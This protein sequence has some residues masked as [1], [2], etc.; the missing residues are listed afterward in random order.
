MLGQC[1]FYFFISTFII[2]II[3]FPVVV[4][5]IAVT[6]ILLLLNTEWKVFV[7]GVILLRIVKIRNIGTVITTY[8]ILIFLVKIVLIIL[9]KSISIVIIGF[10]I[11][12]IFIFIC[13]FQLHTMSGSLMNKIV[14]PKFQSKK[15]TKNK[16][17]RSFHIKLIMNL[18]LSKLMTARQILWKPNQIR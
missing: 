4:N 16:T 15:S 17:L 5:I 2:I 18:E 9:I 6:F 7:F 8:I 13:S 1:Y 14:S 11:V 12:V 3:I 10:I